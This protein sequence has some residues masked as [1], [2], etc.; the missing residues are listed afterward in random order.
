M[1]V[2]AGPGEEEHILAGLDDSGRNAIDV[3]REDV[4]LERGDGRLLVA[5][6][7]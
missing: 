6:R 4:R 7:Q 3:V 5:N 2:Q 1:Q